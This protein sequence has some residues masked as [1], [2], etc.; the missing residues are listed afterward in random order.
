MRSQPFFRRFSES[1]TLGVSGLHP[2]LVVSNLWTMR[3]RSVWLLTLFFL[4]AT[5]LGGS[6]IYLAVHVHVFAFAVRFLD[7][8][9][10]H[11]A[12]M[13]SMFGGD[14]AREEAMAYCEQWD[15]SGQGSGDVG[16][17]SCGSNRTWVPH[18]SKTTLR[19][20]GPRSA[21]C[22]CWWR[23]F[24]SLTTTRTRKSIYFLHEGLLIQTTQYYHVWP[25]LHTCL[26][27][28]DVQGVCACTLV[29][30][31]QMRVA[32][33]KCIFMMIWTKKQ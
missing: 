23:V 21:F 6:Q 26:F 18:V 32:W 10:D 5:K 12:G 17:L 9:L 27:F 4:K 8:M 33:H 30:V 16:S 28:E 19:D 2:C 24:S 11:E 14:V 29:Q 22:I 20:L 31:C 3:S 15:R 13:S 1:F 7:K 25:N